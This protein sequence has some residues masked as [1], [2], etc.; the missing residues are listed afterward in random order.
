MHYAK[1]NRT[2]IFYGTF[3]TYPAAILIHIPQHLTFLLFRTV[4]RVVEITFPAR[5]DD[6]PIARRA[7]KKRHKELYFFRYGAINHVAFRPCAIPEG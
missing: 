6:R 5:I 4:N 7:E 2:I 3:A 1:L